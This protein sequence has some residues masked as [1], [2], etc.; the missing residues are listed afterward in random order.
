MHGRVRDAKLEGLFDERLQFVC[1]PKLHIPSMNRFY[2]FGLGHRA[3]HPDQVASFYV[4]HADPLVG[5][6]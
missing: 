4:S 2:A 6:G 1:S 5:G 3:T